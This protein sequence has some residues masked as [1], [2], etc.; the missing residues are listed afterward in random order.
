MKGLEVTGKGPIV[1]LPVVYSDYC[2]K[3]LPKASSPVG[4]VP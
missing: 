4:S 3:N 1:T 2:E